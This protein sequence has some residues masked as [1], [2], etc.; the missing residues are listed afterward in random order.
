M[1]EE[2][3]VPHINRNV[4]APTVELPAKTPRNQFNWTLELQ[5]KLAKYCKSK[6]A[7]KRTNDIS[8]KVKWE[9][10]LL[11]LQKH[12]EFVGLSLTLMAL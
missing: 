2:P 10:V 1:D 9:A 11:A 4:Q 6:N 5:Y 3:L 7:H 12:D 8:M